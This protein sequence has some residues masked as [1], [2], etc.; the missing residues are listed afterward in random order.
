MENKDLKVEDLTQ[1]EVSQPIDVSEMEGVRSKIDK[2]E[3]ID[4]FSSYD[5]NG[6]W[7][8]GLK[9][10][11]KRLR[12][13]SEVLKEVVVPNKEPIKVRASMIFALKETKDVKGH[14][15]WGWSNSPNSKLFQFLKKL[16]VNTPNE[17]K[18]KYITV[19]VRPSRDAN[20][21]REFLGFAL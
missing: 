3:I 17:L 21:T 13:S 12:V 15:K 16:K 11:V 20:D 4:T 6:N 1:F 14:F 9:R 8:E 7:V 10:P 18:G 19:T 5:E 2:I